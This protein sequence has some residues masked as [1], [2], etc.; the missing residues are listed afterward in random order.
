MSAWTYFTDNCRKQYSKVEDKELNDLLQE[1]RTL[2]DNKYYLSE[3]CHVVRRLLRKP[4]II[5]SYI[6]YMSENGTD[7]RL[8]NFPQDDYGINLASDKSHIMTYFY[9]LINGFNFKNK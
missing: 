7:A 5:Y 3:T 6:L 2:F 4:K 1:V 9:G 8:F